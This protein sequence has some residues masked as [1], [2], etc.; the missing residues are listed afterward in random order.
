MKKIT[1]LFLGLILTIY[2]LGSNNNINID[3]S[4]LDSSIE[5]LEEKNSIGISNPFQQCKTLKEAEKIAGFK[6]KVPQN[7]K[8][9][10]NTYI[11]AIK[12]DLIQLD[13]TSK[14]NE[15]TIRKAIGKS[16]ISGDYREFSQIKMIKL[17]NVEITL[18]G[19]KDLINVAIWEKNNFS[20][21]ISSSLGLTY[22]EIKKIIQSLE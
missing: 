2:V 21:S 19:N 8:K 13:Y 5:I 15:I 14:K 16:D 3:N 18:K 10:K 20:F 12:N 17:K 7:I 11:F 4:N 9:Y 22:N 6:I 1:T